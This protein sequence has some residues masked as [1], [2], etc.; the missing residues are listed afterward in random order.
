MIKA[1]RIVVMTIGAL[2][3]TAGNSWANT[4]VYEE[5]ELFD[6]Q[7]V[8]NDTFTVIDASPYMAILTDFEFPEPWLSPAWPSLQQQS[9]WAA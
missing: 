2:L 4:V 8:L 1:F 9:C 5:V 6:T 3:F 7:K